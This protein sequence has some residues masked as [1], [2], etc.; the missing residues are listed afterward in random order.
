MLRLLAAEPVS[1]AEACRRLDVS[2][3]YLEYRFPAQ[4]QRLRA[5]WA[6]R[7]AGE[8]RQ[9]HDRKVRAIRRIV[10]RLRRRR[11]EPVPVRVVRAYNGDG[12]R[13][14]SGR[15]YRLVRQVIKDDGL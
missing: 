11:L 1:A 6:Q 4:L 5:R 3:G 8:R 14:S 15:I 10:E 7:V 2:L 9:E 12:R 13:K